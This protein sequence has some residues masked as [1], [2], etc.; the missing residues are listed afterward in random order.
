[1]FMRSLLRKNIS[2]FGQTE[3]FEASTC[4]QA[5]KI[6]KRENPDLI[7][8]DVMLSDIHGDTVLHN[9]RKEGIESKVIGVSALGQKQVRE[10]CER[11]GI[12]SYI[13][14]PFDDTEITELIKKDMQQR[15]NR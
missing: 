13:I 7:L 15:G 11:L 14:K 6:A 3:I 2:N 5:L 9:L 10:Q 4:K 1:M 12:S 8:F